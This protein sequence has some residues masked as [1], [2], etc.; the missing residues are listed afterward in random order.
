[1][2]RSGGREIAGHLSGARQAFVARNYEGT[3][4]ACEK[5]LLLDPQN[6]EALDLLD[7]ARTT[8]EEQRLET[9]LT[10]A[11]Q[12]LDQEDIGKAS[13][14]IDQAPRRGSNLEP[15]LAARKRML[16]LRRERERDRERARVVGAVERAQN[17]VGRSE[18]RVRAARR[19]CPDPRAAIAATHPQ[20]SGLCV[21]SAA[22][23]WPRP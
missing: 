2:C 6:V 11:R 19:W 15:A 8:N 3:L 17:Q 16:T 20:G 7:L 9:V 14:L 5:V 13:D 1:M 12:A 21:A 22:S 23:P 10:Q 18:L 4:L